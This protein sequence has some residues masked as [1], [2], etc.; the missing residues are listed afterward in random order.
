MKTTWAIAAAAG[1]ALAAGTACGTQEAKQAPAAP[2]AAADSA[3]ET[4]NGAVQLTK[5]DNGGTV[6]VTVGQELEVRLAGNPTT[7]FSWARTGCEGG[8]VAAVGEGAYVQR[9]AQ[10]GMVGVGG[11]FVFRFRAVK[12]GTTKLTFAYFRPWE[13]GVPPVETFTATVTVAEPAKK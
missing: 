1:L 2:P 10:P 13:K 12:A 5:V 11:E 8:A 9:P 7:G 3:K 6:N 4:A